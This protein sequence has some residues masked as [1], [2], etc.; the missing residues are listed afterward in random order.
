ML[1]KTLK[2]E[3]FHRIIDGETV[4]QICSDPHMP[5]AKQV[6]L[7]VATDADFQRSYKVARLLQVEEIVE[8]ILG[9]EGD[10]PTS[11]TFHRTV[12]AI[13]E[14]LQMDAQPATF[15]DAIQSPRRLS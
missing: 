9:H 7:A 2:S 15:A 10:G 8:E 5:T 4:Q 14:R 1:T 13:R 3:V 11:E 6:Y 12:N